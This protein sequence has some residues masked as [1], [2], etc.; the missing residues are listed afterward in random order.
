MTTDGRG[1]AAPGRAGPVELNPV[2][3]LPTRIARLL[4]WGRERLRVLAT[5][6]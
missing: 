6:R 5:A 2:P 3:E 1:A 4:G